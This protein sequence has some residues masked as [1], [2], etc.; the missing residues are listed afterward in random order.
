MDSRVRL[1][2]FTA[3]LGEREDFFR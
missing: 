3:K 1:L 2:Q